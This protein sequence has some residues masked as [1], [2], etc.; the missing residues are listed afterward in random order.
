MQK[1]PNS[2]NAVDHT[3]ASPPFISERQE[4]P[5]YNRIFW[6]PGSEH[7]GCCAPMQDASST[8]VQVYYQPPLFR[9]QTSKP[10]VITCTHITFCPEVWAQLGS[11]VL[12]N[13]GIICSSFFKG[14]LN[15]TKHKGVFIWNPFSDIYSLAQA[16]RR[17]MV[18]DRD[19][20]VSGMHWLLA[21]LTASKMS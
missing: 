20:M 10:R 19:H 17:G 3:I 9:R 8:S 15:S 7:Q 5:M 14:A 13:K 21:K 18:S 1:I 16:W 6:A 11:F 2:Y 4:I 12:P